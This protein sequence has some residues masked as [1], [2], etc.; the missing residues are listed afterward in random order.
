MANALGVWAWGV[1]GWVC[2]AEVTRIN[3]TSAGLD[4]VAVAHLARAVGPP[5]RANT[6]GGISREPVVATFRP[7]TRFHLV[8]SAS[9]L[10]RA[11]RNWSASKEEE[12]LAAGWL[13]VGGD[14]STGSLGKP[15][16]AAAVERVVLAV[17]G[18]RHEETGAAPSTTLLEFLR[19]RTPVRGPK[20]GCGEGELARNI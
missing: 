10:P 13:V 4:P 7:V 2:W 1:G 12:E 6:A 17:N 16:A 9:L 15:E 8:P 20:L 18:A 14:R 19:T 3:S 11:D 5:L